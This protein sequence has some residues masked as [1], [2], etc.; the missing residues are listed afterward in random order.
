[1]K[2]KINGISWTKTTRRHVW[3]HRYGYFIQ[4]GRGYSWL[5]QNPRVTKLLSY[6][7]Q[8][9]GES[10]TRSEVTDP[11]T[12]KVTSFKYIL[13]DH[14]FVDNARHRVYIAHEKTL[15]FMALTA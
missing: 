11:E 4:L 8:T 3:G 6:L 5:N 1:M 2:V 10:S 15:T 12:G 14:W 7:R 9:Y 13:N